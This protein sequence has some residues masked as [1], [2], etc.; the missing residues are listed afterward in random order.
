MSAVVAGSTISATSSTLQSARPRRCDAE[1]DCADDHSRRS[2]LI[3]GP[4]V[5]ILFN[6]TPALSRPHAS[7]QLL[8][9]P[10]HNVCVRLPAAARTPTREA[11][12]AAAEPA[13]RLA[14]PAAPRR[15]LVHARDWRVAAAPAEIP[16]A[17]GE[18]EAPVIRVVPRVELDLGVLGLRPARHATGPQPEGKRAPSRFCQDVHV[19]NPAN[20]RG[21]NISGTKSY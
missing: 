10:F 6:V 20:R 14:P 15:S 5:A 21:W 19:R 7:S 11:L 3:N 18:G 1:F 12:P 2:G 4:C 9:P 13:E 16:T 8:S 17:P